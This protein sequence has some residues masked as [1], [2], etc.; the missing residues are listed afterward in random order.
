[1]MVSYYS[2]EGF[3]ED[4][5][6]GDKYLG[7][8]VV[9]WPDRK[10][11]SAGIIDQT[12]TAPILLLRNLRS[13]LYKASPKK[14]L[15]VSC[16]LFPLCGRALRVGDKVRVR[17]DYETRMRALAP[18]EGIIET[19]EPPGPAGLIGLRSGNVIWTENYWQVQ[20]IK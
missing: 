12:I 4:F 8:R 14:P 9:E 15:H 20:L 11:G 5:F 6:E 7:K 18:D 17:R 2:V 19:M 10:M 3:Y 13:I 16:V 1:M